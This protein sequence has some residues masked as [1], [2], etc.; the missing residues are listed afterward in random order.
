VKWAPALVEQ[1]MNV[2]QSL[3]QGDASARDPGYEFWLRNDVNTNIRSLSQTKI[4]RGEPQIRTIN[5]GKILPP[6]CNIVSRILFYL[7]ADPPGDTGYCD[8]EV[9]TGD[10]GPP[11]WD[12][13]RRLSEDKKAAVYKLDFPNLVGRITFALELK[14]L[15][16]APSSFFYRLCCRAAAN[17]LSLKEFPFQTC[18]RG[19]ACPHNKKPHVSVSRCSCILSRPQ[20]AS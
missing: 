18:R 5:D 3:H 4:C 14:N 12:T 2:L 6:L 19:T 13:V 8:F 9:Q 7:D 20:G 10:R 16:V 11:I 1:G 15:T 17:L